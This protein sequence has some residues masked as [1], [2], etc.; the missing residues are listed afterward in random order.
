MFPN[1][2]FFESFLRIDVLGSEDMVIRSFVKGIYEKEIFLLS[3]LIKEKNCTWGI[4][5]HPA[6]I[7]LINSKVGKNSNDDF[8]NSN[9][10]LE[11]IY[12]LN[13]DQKYFKYFSAE[14]TIGEKRMHV[15]LRISLI[16][17]IMYIKEQKK[18]G[19]RIILV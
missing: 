7:C 11:I 3:K 8:K 18:A 4:L 10:V 1:V 6:G 16:I 13:T 2:S 14:N 5:I 15:F 9:V 19:M 17:K 12:G